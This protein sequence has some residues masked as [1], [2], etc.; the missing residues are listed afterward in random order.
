M[1]AG[2]KVIFRRI[3]KRDSEVKHQIDEQRAGILSQKHLRETVTE[4]ERY[5]AF[6]SFPALSSFA[7]GSVFMFPSYKYPM[8]S[9]R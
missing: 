8:L 7:V 3:N 9:Q 1:F 6:I 4:Q 2:G 5:N